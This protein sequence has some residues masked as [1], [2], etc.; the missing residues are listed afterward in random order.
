M[1]KY[2]VRKNIFRYE[3]KTHFFGKSSHINPIGWETISLTQ[4]FGD[5][6]YKEIYKENN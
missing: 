4:E 3:N 5:L 1:T 6:V 2:I